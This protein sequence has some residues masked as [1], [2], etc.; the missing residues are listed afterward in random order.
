MAPL[1]IAAFAAAW[2][3]LYRQLDAI[4]YIPSDY[5]A[6]PP[7]NPPIPLPQTPQPDMPLHPLIL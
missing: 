5:G 4:G 7:H 3:A 2:T 6:Y 1:D